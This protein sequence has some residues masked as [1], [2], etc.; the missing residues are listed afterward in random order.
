MGFLR[1]LNTCITDQLKCIYYFEIKI[2]ELL[3]FFYPLLTKDTHFSDIILR[4]YNKVKTVKDLADLTHYSISGFEKRFKRVFGISP[5]KWLKKQKAKNI[6][7][8]INY[9]VKTFKEISLEYDFTSPSH[10]NNFCK[11]NFGDTPGNI[12][13]QS[14]ISA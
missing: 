6:Y 11:T 1:M 9:S 10:L 5:Y 13:R 4:N 14:K 8:E 3:N 12:R 2:K 7:R